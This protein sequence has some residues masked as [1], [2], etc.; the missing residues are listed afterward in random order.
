MAVSQ[1]ANNK[2][3]AASKSGTATAR[4]YFDTGLKDPEENPF[5]VR[6]GSNKSLFSKG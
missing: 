3:H 6:D 1:P 2:Q 5:D 4:I